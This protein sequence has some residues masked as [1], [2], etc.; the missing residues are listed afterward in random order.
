VVRL[1]FLAPFAA[2]GLLV[3]AG[4][5]IRRQAP[6]SAVGFERASPPPGDPR[7]WPTPARELPGGARRD[8]TAPSPAT[9]Q[10][11]E[12]P[13]PGPPAAAQAPDEPPQDL[14]ATADAPHRRPCQT[15]RLARQRYFQEQQAKK[16]AGLP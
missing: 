13:T 12:T 3:I 16:R 4:A 7:A 10:A 2:L 8:P 5:T 14:S 1:R 6:I 11:T 15:Y 9:A